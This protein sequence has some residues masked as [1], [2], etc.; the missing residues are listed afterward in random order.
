MAGH[1]EQDN[2]IWSCDSNIKAQK[3]RY[4]NL[5]ATKKTFRVLIYVSWKCLRELLPIAEAV[6][7]KLSS[8]IKF[9]YEFNVNNVISGM[10]DYF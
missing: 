6:N 1:E 5:P 10:Y 3:L 9:E 7:R 2:W 8:S 4:Y